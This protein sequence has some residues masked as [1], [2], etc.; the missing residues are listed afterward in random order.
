[1]RAGARPRAAWP[2][3]SRRRGPGGTPDSR[4]APGRSGRSSRAPRPGQPG[5]VGGEVR[6][7]GHRLTARPHRRRAGRAASRSAARCGGGRTPASPP[8]S[9]PRA[10]GSV[11][12]R[13]PGYQ[14]TIVRDGYAGYH[15]LS[16][17]VHAWCGRPRAAAGP[18][19]PRP[20]GH[21]PAV[22]HRPDRR[23]HQQPGRARR[24]PRQ[25]SA[26]HL[27]RMLA[28]PRRARR[29]RDRPVLPLHRRS[30]AAKWGIDPL[31]ALTQLLTTGPWRPSAIRPA[32]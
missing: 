27:R 24:P 26:A 10:A 5:V 8:P 20:S 29:L 31:D 30:T 13:S 25:S 17:A 32:E 1:M 4:D 12:L 22:R 18:P 15:H 7:R 16:D 6:R 28:D 23:V 2:L 19:V 3:R 11:P 21:D 9:R 14:G